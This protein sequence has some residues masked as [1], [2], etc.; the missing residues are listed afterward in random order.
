MRERL[1]VLVAGEREAGRAREQIEEADRRPHARLDRRPDAPRCDRVEHGG[2]DRLDV[3]LHGAERL[4]R[5]VPRDEVELLAVH[6]AALALAQHVGDLED[7]RRA[8]AQHP[9][10][11]ELG[12]RREKARRRRDGLD[13]RLGRGRLDPH[14][15]RHLGEPPGAQTFAHRPDRG[16]PGRDALGPRQP[17]DH[18]Y[19]FTRSMYAPER[20]S[21]LI[22]SPI[23]M[24]IGTATS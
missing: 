1:V 8:A 4:A 23:L 7:R 22:F 10:H 19:R 15:R 14:R 3:R 5:A 16:I 21:I 13:P 12:A 9:L 18:R 11:R 6:R 2:D 17:G 24:K 20:V